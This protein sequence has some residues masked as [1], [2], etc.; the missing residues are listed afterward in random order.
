MSFLPQFHQIVEMRIGRAEYVPHMIPFRI[1]RLDSIPPFS[2][3]HMSIDVQFEDDNNSLVTAMNVRRIVIFRIHT[4]G[5]SIETVRTHAYM[6]LQNGT[7]KRLY[8]ALSAC[9]R[10][11][12][13]SSLSSMPTD[14]RTRPSVIPIASRCSWVTEACVVVAE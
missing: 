13:R 2:Q 5:N 8:T 11:A 9:S 3:S 10:S 14:S 4:E 12:I 1:A 6:I 7:P